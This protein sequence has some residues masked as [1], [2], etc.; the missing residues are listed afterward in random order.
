MAFSGSSGSSF[1]LAAAQNRVLS[2]RYQQL[3]DSEF[4]VFLHSFQSDAYFA[5]LDLSH[6]LLSDASARLLSDFIRK[7]YSAAEEIHLEDN[8]IGEAG[9]EELEKARNEA[10]QAHHRSWNLYLAGNP[11]SQ[12]LIGRLEDPLTLPFQ[13]IQ[14]VAPSDTLPALSF[15]SSSSLSLEPIPAAEVSSDTFSSGF[16]S[17]RLLPRFTSLSS[18][19]EDWALAPNS[20]NCRAKGWESLPYRLQGAVHLKRLAVG[21]NQVSRIENLPVDL[22]ALELCFNQIG[23]IEGLERLARLKYLD[24]G[25]NQ[26]GEIAGLQGNADLVEIRLGHNRIRTVTGLEHLQRLKRLDLSSNLLSNFAD[27]R[28]LALNLSL[29]VLFLAGN[30]L[31]ELSGYEETVQA[32]LP[33][34]IKLDSV[35]F[36]GAGP[37][38]PHSFFSADFS[39]GEDREESSFALP[40]LSMPPQ[41]PSAQPVSKPRPDTEPEE[42]F[43]PPS[44]SVSYSSSRKPSTSS[45]FPAFQALLTEKE[46]ES[47]IA[48]LLTF[49]LYRGFP[50]Q[51]LHTLL[52]G[53]ERHRGERGDV[54][55]DGKDTVKGVIVV[56]KGGVWWK[57]R[58][59]GPGTVLFPDSLYAAVPAEDNVVCA[60]RCEYVQIDQMSM[61]D[62]LSANPSLAALLAANSSSLPLLRH[63]PQPQ[64]LPL[65]PLFK[66]VRPSPS[67]T[68]H[69]SSQQTD[70]RTRKIQAE[71]AKLFSGD[72]FKPESGDFPVLAP[73]ESFSTWKEAVQSVKSHISSL[74]NYYQ[75]G[76]I[77]DHESVQIE[78]EALL[79]SSQGPAKV[80]DFLAI[81]RPFLRETVDMAYC[82]PRLDSV[83]EIRPEGW[84]DASLMGREP[85]LS[86]KP[87]IEKWT[88]AVRHD[89]EALAGAISQVLQGNIEEVLQERLQTWDQTPSHPLE[90]VDNPEDFLRKMC[91]EQRTHPE[92]AHL[93]GFLIQLARKCAYLKQALEELLTAAHSGERDRVE[94]LREEM[95][96]EGVVTF[97][98]QPNLACVDST[99]HGDSSA[100]AWLSKTAAARPDSSVPS[101]VSSRR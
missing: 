34:V 28:P 12:G 61:H 25:H 41:P 66:S 53:V 76:A 48:R 97:S 84:L 29:Q 81:Q 6:N 36:Q 68:L 52:A 51:E 82:L 47:I 87:A 9:G 77:S 78:A 27:I 71:I 57:G 2:L 86:L 95:V 30:P 3:S 94:R 17:P 11:M 100:R 60:E 96:K 7:S 20:A 31:C 22:E 18:A 93:A 8:E 54:L 70:T 42:P 13:Q 99:G 10:F 26:I 92:I 24:L 58:K 4:A 37:G 101:G 1:D 16:F 44:Q 5:V 35:S 80:Y 79:F 90:L 50:G 75:I 88:A 56:L 89:I 21:R 55:Q 59:H 40:V 91:G 43:F 14:Q 32:M 98:L 67:Q 15:A 64:S 49:P 83:S 45:Q 33:V 19:S 72:P 63:S 38:S 46:Q 69:L 74:A 65:P 85:D 73:V 23:Q 39:L 62:L